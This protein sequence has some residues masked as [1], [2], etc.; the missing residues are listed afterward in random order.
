[1]PPFR[2]KVTR[3]QA[4]DLLAFIRA[5]DRSQP[6]RVHATPTDFESRFQQLEQEFEN[7]RD[8][9]GPSPRTPQEPKAIR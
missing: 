8:K 1:M 7:L 4:R 5:F 9:S 2:E 6:K 3:E